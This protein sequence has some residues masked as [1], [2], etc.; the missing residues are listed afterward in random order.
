MSKQTT[1]PLAVAESWLALQCQIIPGIVRAA[2]FPGQE[3]DSKYPVAHACW[4]PGSEE[5]AGLRVASSRALAQN[6][7]V[8]C[9]EKGSVTD[10]AAVQLN[11]A[12]PILVEGQ[13]YGV[14]AVELASSDEQ[15]QRTVL[16]MLQWGSRWLQ[17]ILKQEVDGKP[18]ISTRVLRIVA[19]GL[20]PSRFQAAATAA[21]TELASSL[22]CERVS[23]GFLSGERVRLQALS[24]SANFNR[25]ANLVRDLELAMAEALDQQA[26]LEYPPR[27]QERKRVLSAHSQLCQ[28]HRSGTALSVPLASGDQL[29]GVITFERGNNQPFDD[30]TLEQCEVIAS[31]LGPILELKRERERSVLAQVWDSAREFITSLLGPGHALTKLLAIIASTAIVLLSLLTGEYRS[32][33]DA[34]LEGSIQRVVV[35]PMDGFIKSASVRPGDMVK[36]G[37]VLGTLDDRELQLEHLRWS[38]QRAQLHK[39]YREALGNRERTQ[40]GILNAEIAQADAQLQL[41]AEQL[42]RTEFVAP[43]DGVVVSGDLS[44]ELGSPVK[45]GRVLFT[46]APLNS[47]RVVVQV[48]EREVSE[49]SSGQSGQ[50]V[51]FARPDQVMALT[52]ESVTPVSTPR[53]GNNYF[54]VEAS[55]NAPAEELRPGMQGVAKIDIEQ[56]RLIWI[57]THRL[58]D[59]LRL[60]FWSWLA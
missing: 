15:R 6:R 53:D 55:L 36:A 28:Q 25:Q 45:R 14:I 19:A 12:C 33:G 26:T 16:Q 18:D 10:A 8:V 56:R 59:W 5:S 54:R 4:P 52:V 9:C 31:M 21:A 37:Q 24:N 11:I 57:W 47:Y 40:V 58:V 50:L 46:V 27:Q 3:T 49:I 48:D 22:Q 51:L 43:F 17:I 23:I 2:V 20:E 35:A 13:S 38:G 42:A 29:V 39:E 30:E 41:L 34:V 7:P 44:Q 1:L 60:W 32:T